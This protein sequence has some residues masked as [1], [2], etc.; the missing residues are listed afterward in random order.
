MASP[1]RKHFATNGQADTEN[2]LPAVPNPAASG[3]KRR[4]VPPEMATGKLA[5]PLAAKLAQHASQA[6]AKAA[7][8]AA[9]KPAA[10]AETPGEPEKDVQYFS[11]LYTKKSTK[12]KLCF[13]AA[14][15]SAMHSH[16]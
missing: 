13:A 9:A 10:E 14:Q 3:A 8:P 4:F 2:Q 5:Q 6:A 7:H 16:A 11:V 12:V 15:S 1:K